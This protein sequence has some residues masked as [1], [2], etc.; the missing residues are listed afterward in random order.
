MVKSDIGLDKM[1]IYNPDNYI[2]ILWLYYGY[3]LTYDPIP[4]SYEA[5]PSETMG[6]KNTYLGPWNFHV[7]VTKMIGETFGLIGETTLTWK[8]T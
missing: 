5:P 8:I 1:I 4:C 3:M 7:M 6:D 2:V